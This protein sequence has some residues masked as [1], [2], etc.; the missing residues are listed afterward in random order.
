MTTGLFS[1][2]RASFLGGLA[3]VCAAAL[4]VPACSGEETEAP[5]DGGPIAV[6]AIRSELQKADC[7]HQVRCGFMPDQATCLDVT[8]TDQRTL[9]LLA[10]V[11]FG[12]VTY[13]PAAARACVNAKRAQ[14]CDSLASVVETAKQACESV[15]KGSVA[16]GGE[17]LWSEECAG[18]SVCD[19][20]MCAGDGACCLGVC[21]PAPALV[22]L[23][24]DCSMG[25][26]C[27][28]DAFCE[29]IP[30]DEMTPA[31][32]TCKERVDNGQAC[33]SQDGCFEGQRCDVGGEN[34][35]FIL[36]K[37]GGAC[38]P[39]IK[40]SPCVSIDNWCHK[41]D[42]KCVKLPGAGE[43]CAT[44]GRC[45]GYAYCDTA[46]MTCKAFPR[47]GEACVKDGPGCLGDLYCAI[48]E[49]AMDGVCTRAASHE[50]CVIGHLESAP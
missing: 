37:E 5:S 12:K 28:K 39:S 42:R 46:G 41:D 44:D 23:G 16:E 22:S 30:G 25:A 9:Q 50:V 29:T 36:Q 34:K 48:P 21:K 20:A 4:L 35:C 17:C 38:N 1:T 33:T 26:T 15:F 3:L 45:Q 43:P 47:E 27:V 32:S 18:D 11:V 19:T 8:A 2:Y 10:D 40:T 14:T 49:M 7:E 24:G 31:V 6:E 13:D